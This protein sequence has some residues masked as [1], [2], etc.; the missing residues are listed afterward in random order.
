[1]KDGLDEEWA[2]RPL[3]FIR[4]GGQITLVIEDPGGEPLELHLTRPMEVRRF[5]QLAISIA[6]AL[7]NL[8]QRGL[9]LTIVSGLARQVPSL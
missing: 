1:M 4:E 9:V 3:E 6:A 8:H 5:L 7:G 2:A